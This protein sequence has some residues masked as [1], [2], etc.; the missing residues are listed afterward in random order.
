MYVKFRCAERRFFHHFQ[1]VWFDN[2]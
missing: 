1:K 2:I